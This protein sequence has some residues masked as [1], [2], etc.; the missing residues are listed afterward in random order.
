MSQ[1]E[2]KFLVIGDAGWRNSYDPSYDT[3]TECTAENATF[4]DGL[5]N[6]HK[7]INIY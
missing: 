7:M 3:H 1:D 2:Y 4:T 6:F 5:K